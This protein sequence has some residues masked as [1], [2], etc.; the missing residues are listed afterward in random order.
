MA[1]KFKKKVNG[2]TW[3]NGR[4]LSTGRKSMIETIEKYGSNMKCSVIVFQPRA[5]LSKIN[6][7]RKTR[8]GQ[9]YKR[10]QQLDTLLLGAR[11][12]CQSAGAEFQVWVDK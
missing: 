9:A 7:T 4:K 10:L 12:A 3:K 2:A 8:R 11:Q 1:R 5:R 6:K